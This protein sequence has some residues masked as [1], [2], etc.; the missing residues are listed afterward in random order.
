M[1]VLIVDDHALLRDGLT[2]LLQHFGPETRVLSAADGAAALETPS[3]SATSILRSSTWP[4]RG[5]AGRP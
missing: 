2:A 1:K 5:W 3:V 4:C